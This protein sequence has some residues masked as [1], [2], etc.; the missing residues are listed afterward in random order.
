MLSIE[1]QTGFHRGELAVQ[2]R[3]GV[4]SDAA[5]LAGMLAPAHLDGGV[6][7]FLAQRE[8][9]ALTSRDHDGRLWIS[10]LLG[11]AGFLDAHGTTL[12]VHALPT[13]TDPAVG[14][15]VGLIAVEF[16]I[17]RRLRVN[18]TLTS[19]GPDGLSIEADQAYGNCPSYIQQRVV[20]RDSAAENS[21]EVTTSDGLS[22]TQQAL[23]RNADT[24][25]LGT[26]HPT[27]GADASHKGG[28]PGFVRTDGD[29]LWWPDYSGNNMFNSMGNLAVDP[30]AALLFVDF[31]TGQTLRLSGTAELEWITPGSPGDD[32]G[33]GRRIRFRPQR[34]M[35]GALPMRSG[36]VNPSP[37]NPSL[38]A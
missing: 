24:F 18:G 10:P 14:Q 6:A 32:D 2:R 9:A 15:P 5:R 4:T 36:E 8:F 35:T 12:D 13:G 29:E 38:A 17:R 34:V 19:I 1:E 25:F 28:R 20:E 37:H 26:V 21:S 27:R 22:P 33:T 7:R 23:I 31:A 11:P 16:A 30:T 3:A